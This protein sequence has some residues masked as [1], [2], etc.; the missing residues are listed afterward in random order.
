MADLAHTRHHR[1]PDH[2]RT[3]RTQTLPH[4]MTTATVTTRQS[5]F[6]VAMQ[7]CGTMEA[8]FDLAMLNELS[9]SDDLSS[10]SQIALVEPQDSRAVQT[11]AVNRQRPATAVTQ[12]EILDILD[13]GEGI[14]FW[15]I[16]FD[17]EVSSEIITPPRPL[18]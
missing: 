12:S 10:G 16:E 13:Q 15:G 5:L 11:F 4:N 3:N 8:A 1:R 18:T 7:H 14:E 2:Y 6:D 9:L 17:F